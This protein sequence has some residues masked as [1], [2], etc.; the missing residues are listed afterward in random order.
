MNELNKQIAVPY[1]KSDRVKSFYID[2][3]EFDMFKQLVLSN[4]Q[5]GVNY[6]LLFK[7]KYNGSHF[8]MVGPQ[9]GFK[10]L[11][12][13][14]VKSIELLYDDLVNLMENFMDEYNAEEI[15]LIQVLYIV[16]SEN[17]KLK[18][19]NI[20][21][22]SLNRG[23]VNVK[24]AR[25]KFN[26]K[27]LPIT[28]NNNYFGKLLVNDI[29]LSYFDKINYQRELVGKDV[30]NVD[31]ID[32]MYLYLDKFV[33]V[34]KRISDTFFIRHIY[35]AGSGALF[36]NVEDT[37]IN[38]NTFVRKIS[39]ISLT[40]SKDKVI[41]MEVEKDLSIIKYEPKFTKEVSNPFIGSLD[42]EAFEDLDGYA[43][44]YALGFAVL[45]KE[46][47]IFFL[48]E[49]Q[50]SDEL[51]LKCFDIMLDKYSGY[52]FYTH[53]FGKYD[54]I[55][56][57]KIIKEANKR[58][59]FE[60]Y[61]LSPIYKDNMLLKLDVKINKKSGYNKITIVD[62][63]NLLNSGLFNLSR[64]F[65]I[66]ITKGYFPHKF[67]KRDT[68]NYVG[69]TPSIN[70]WNNISNDEYK[71]LYKKDWSLKDECISYLIKDLESLLKIMDTFN[72]YILRNYD[73]QMTNC[74]TIS[75]LALNIFLKHY[76]KE[77][78]LPIIKSY[79]FKDIKQAYYG[80]VTEVYKPYG[81]NLLYYDVNSL[82]PMVSL[83]PIP[84]NK[85][86]YLE[87][88]SDVG[89]NLNDLF[90][91][92]YCD[93]E[94]ENNYLGLLPVRSDI[95]LIMPN[96]K[97]KGW[98]FSEELKFA[99][100]NGYKI[101]VIKGYN[102]N[103]Q[104]NIFNEYVNDLYKIKSSSMGHIRVIAKSLLNNLLGRFGM[105]INKPITDI[106]NREKLEL[107]I[108]TR[109]INSFRE[110]TDEDFLITYYPEISQTICKSHGVDYLK[111]LKT[112]VDMERDKEL[113]DVSLSTAAAVTSYARIYLSKIKLDILNKGG[114]IY[115]TDTDSIVTD[116][117]LNKELVGS[118]LGQFKL[119]YEVKEGYFISSKTYCLVLKNGST[120]IKTKGL[121][122]NSLTLKDFKNM[123]KG[124]SV[125]GVKLNTVTIYEE[126]SVVIG[127]KEI[128]LNYNSYKKREKIYKWSRWVNTKPLIYN[129]INRSQS[130]N[131]TQKPKPIKSSLIRLS[132]NSFTWKHNFSTYAN[133]SMRI[134][135]R[136]FLKKLLDSIINIL[137]YILIIF[138]LSILFIIYLLLSDYDDIDLSNI[139]N[140]IDLDYCNNPTN[141][142][143]KQELNNFLDLFRNKNIDK[144]NFNVKSV[145]SII[146]SQSNIENHQTKLHD[147]SINRIN[148]RS[149]I[150]KE[151]RDLHF[152]STIQE[153]NTLR[154]QIS[155]L[156]IQILN[157]RLDK[158][159]TMKTIDE[160]TRDLNVRLVNLRELNNRNTI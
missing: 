59:E 17:P 84:G 80:G 25:Q 101:K 91:Y 67:V 40:I 135:K 35:S 113:K 20:N 125:K 105:N 144:Q 130:F 48:N 160:L 61:K 108:S 74:R 111:A 41:N 32:S 24:E 29:R 36:Q 82:Y 12:I 21:K 13:D 93:I 27:F 31:D 57:V 3:L 133:K 37:L 151:V 15:E 56:I 117:L 9:R 95:G 100:F 90:G 98:Y 127:E 50:S 69:N 4:L 155:L 71:E 65:D 128:E 44:V 156:E 7:F 42:L 33:I 43:K 14:D 153:N 159:D 5:V 72:K 96:G 118:K 115:Y 85:C 158:L 86:T 97:W 10:L 66:D 149:L 16:V 132:S 11:S 39:N 6:S 54:S 87:V 79:M 137:I 145:N 49:N 34:N 53:N 55:F 150:L 107:I 139:N 134:Y 83:N 136:Y 119:E 148:D 143:L 104:E 116:I 60:Y 157:L 109:E 52:I 99:A 138:I 123:Y 154:E 77:S 47:K 64:S 129:E 94:T 22:I 30:L 76:L 89:L 2:Y 58:K 46:V 120:V 124:I 68:L 141:S 81:K 1:W 152:K 121:Y 110:L 51:L 19:E 140:E 62:S 147:E 38:K 103:K 122:N 8:G 63:Y 28:V 18:L 102:F 114:S 78:K 106:V 146:E 70:Y 112:K 75:R 23:F 73:V 126:G 26:V 88:F 45:G 92:F 142:M 131:K